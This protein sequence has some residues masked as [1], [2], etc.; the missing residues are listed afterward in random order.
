[1]K[2]SWLAI[3]LIVLC[4][5]RGLPVAFAERCDR[6][7]S[8]APSVTEVLFELGLGE[9]IVG[10]T[11]YCRYPV[12]AQSLPTIGGFYDISFESLLSRKPTVVIGLREHADIW[13]SSRRFGLATHQV[14]HSTIQGIK[15][16]ITSIADICGIA[17]VGAEKVSAL[18]ARERALQD[19]ARGMPHY[20]TLVAVGRTHEGSSTS[21]VYVSG[22]DGFYS[23][24]LEILG[25]RNVNQEPTIALPTISSE[26]IM[27]LA[28]EVIVEVVGADD[29]NNPEDHEALWRR[30]SNIPAVK[31]DRI[32]TLRGD[33]A[34]IPGPRYILVAED[35]A[36]K[37]QG[38]GP[39]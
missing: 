13:E 7:V 34:S 15:K 28:P 1:M 18:E 14:D 21:G 39:R 8:L 36:R 11:R 33:Y 24:L 16:S 4:A 6:I 3:F 9:R 30:Y 2:R 20:K 10:V 32:I 23:G 27:A 5:G 35:I 38:E 26:G 19:S 31:N 12:E 22:T 17:K 37:L 25:L 29:P